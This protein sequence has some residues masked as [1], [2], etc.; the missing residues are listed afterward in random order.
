MDEAISYQYPRDKNVHEIFEQQALNHPDKIAIIYDNKLLTYQE[1]NSLANA[2]ASF[3]ITQDIKA[4]D[5]V[6][7]SSNRSLEM[8]VGLLAILKVGII[9]GW[10]L[11]RSATTSLVM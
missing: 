2:V 6:G 1:L 9:G 5:Y 11:G 7:I 10:I 8:V 3:L 4:H